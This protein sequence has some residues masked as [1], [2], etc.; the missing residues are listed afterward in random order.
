MNAIDNLIYTYLNPTASG[1]AIISDYNLALT[2]ITRNN[3]VPNTKIPYENLPPGSGNYSYPVEVRNDFTSIEDSQII[4]KAIQ[5]HWFD[6]QMLSIYPA[7][8]SLPPPIYSNLSFPP[9]HLIYAFLLE[10]TRMVQIFE[11]LLTIFFN[12]ELFSISSNKDVVKWINNTENLFFKEMPNS[13]Y[14]NI[15]SLVRIYPESSRRNAYKRLFGMDLSFGDFKN[16]E[17]PYPYYKA[18]VTNNGFVALFE[19]FLKEVWQAYINATN[20]SGVNTT[21]YQSISDLVFRIQQTLMSRRASGDDFII[22]SNYPYY[23]LSRE[24]FSSVIMVTWFFHVIEYSSPLIT[25]LNCDATTAGERLI[26]LGNKVGIKAHRKSQYIFEMA[27]QLAD[28][29]RKIEIGILDVKVAIQTPTIDL[30][31][32]LSII[33]NWEITTG[34]VIKTSVTPVKMLR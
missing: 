10:N 19:Q 3:Y 9:Y 2:D 18:T 1:A 7:P 5:K 20:T 34:H 25:F 27:P 15:S 33:N 17:Q 21:D 24:E 23:N 13:A 6:M 4:E 31:Y 16:N 28:I 14:R 32:L 8:P 26:K 29:L 11:K 30:N 22:S 12:D